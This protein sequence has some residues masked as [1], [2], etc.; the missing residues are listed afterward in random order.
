MEFAKLYQRVMD[1][2]NVELLNAINVECD[3][4]MRALPDERFWKLYKEC[5]EDAFYYD[6]DNED[7]LKEFLKP[8]S[9]ED[10]FW[11]IKTYDLD[12]NNDY[13]VENPED[14][15]VCWTVDNLADI[16]M[17]DDS[18]L[19][20]CVDTETWWWLD[21]DTEEMRL[22]LEEAELECK[23]KFI[24]EM[25]SKIADLNRQITELEK[26]LKGEK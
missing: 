4:Q 20:W 5:N 17:Y 12:L 2:N 15:D 26:Q 8:F 24:S 14:S 13:Y 3:R 9:A 22:L 21:T 7:D 23:D 19:N 10:L 1:S 25:E 6:L 18:L 16:I 11:H